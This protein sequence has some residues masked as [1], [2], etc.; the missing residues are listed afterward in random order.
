[1][2]N[3]REIFGDID[4]YLFD[5]I[6]KGRFTSEMKILDAGCGGGRNIIYFMRSGCN[7]FAVDQNAEAIEQIKYLAKIIAPDLPPENFQTA[8]IEK[9]PFPDNH[10][11]WVISNAV[12]HFAENKTQFDEMLAEM[13]RVLKPNGTLFVRLASSIGIEH[14]VIPT[15]NGRYDLP[16]GSERF[17]V[18]EHFLIAAT[19]NLGGSFLEPIKTTNVQNMRCMTTWILYKNPF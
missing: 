2:K 18:S 12:L 3:I 10:L 6:Q 16:D 4:I 9:M 5:Q 13:W 8:N 17:L 11:D 19:Q 1:M 15:E 14:L 7:V